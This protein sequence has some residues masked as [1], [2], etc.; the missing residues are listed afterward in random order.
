MIKYLLI[1]VAVLLFIWILAGYL[2]AKFLT[3]TNQVTVRDI[4]SLEGRAVQ[5]LFIKTEDGV[6]VSSWFVENSTEKAIILLSGI[7]VDKTRQL[8]RAKFYLD[9]GYSV[10]MPDLRGTG[11][12][13]GDFISFGWQESKDLIACFERLKTMGF[14]KI[15]ANGQSLGAATIVYATKASLDFDFI[16][17]ESCY[18]NISNALKNRVRNFPAPH[19][20]Y[21]PATF[22]TAKIIDGAQESLVPDQIITQIEC[23]TLIMAGDTEFQIRTEETEKLYQNSGAKVK[24]LHFFK[25]GEHEDFYAR[26]P[27][28]F[29]EV[30]SGFLNKIP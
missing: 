25:G 16:I 13:Q 30:V 2:A 11:K 27:T 18:D 6:T 20:L 26:F 5:H 15:G 23:P 21:K 12:T 22:F 7:R 10:L 28:E 24:Q 1:L 29:E 14:T 19:F 17:L 8:E 4:Q 9:K 3:R